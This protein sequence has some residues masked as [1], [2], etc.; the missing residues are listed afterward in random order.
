MA[1]LKKIKYFPAPLVIA[2]CGLFL[3]TACVPV[4][5]QKGNK[6][7]KPKKPVAAATPKP[8]L[9]EQVS[10]PLPLPP[11][12]LKRNERPGNEI[13]GDL[14]PTAAKTNSAA[15]QKKSDP[16]Y[17]YEFTQP[18]FTTSRIVI[19]HDDQGKGTIAFTR[20]GNTEVIT[21][22]IQISAKALEKLKGAFTALNFYDSTENYQHERDFSHLGVIRIAV[23]KRGRERSTTFNYTLNKNAKTLADEYRKITNQALWI[24]DITTARENQP[25]ESPGQM[26]LLESLIKRDEISDGEQM[27]PFLR[28]LS[29]DERIP[30]IARNHATRIVQTIEKSAKKNK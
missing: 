20:R 18:E 7:R 5:A 1:K 25:L 26:N 27:L 15:P 17:F 10:D 13:A 9:E 8:K 21:D 6:S 28:E 23:T 19:E 16:A 22:P 3:A 30:L 11:P 12:A 24:F 4:F 2:L 29:D 14:K